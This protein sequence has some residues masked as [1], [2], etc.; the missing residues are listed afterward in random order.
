MGIQIPRQV[1][2]F[3]ISDSS[4]DSNLC[5]LKQSFVQ[6][7]LSHDALIRRSTDTNKPYPTKRMVTTSN[8]PI[9]NINQAASVNRDLLALIISRTAT[10]KCSN[11]DKLVDYYG[12]FYKWVWNAQ[13]QDRARGKTGIGECK[14]HHYMIYTGIEN[15]LFKG[16]KKVRPHTESVHNILA[17][18]SNII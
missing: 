5:I 1:C 11:V 6:F 13:Y 10:G 4:K 9:R 7:Y 12:E 17:H 15:H 14:M 3:K 2:S 8:G 16:N 18:G